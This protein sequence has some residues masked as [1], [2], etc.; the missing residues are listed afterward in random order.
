MDSSVTECYVE[1]AVYVAERV[2]VFVDFGRLFD[3]V[4]DRYENRG[5]ERV[6]D[7]SRG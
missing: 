1:V 2:G 5:E 7:Q 3:Y 4:A 6:G